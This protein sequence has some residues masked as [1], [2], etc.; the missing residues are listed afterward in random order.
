[1]NTNSSKKFVLYILKNEKNS[2]KSLKF[3]NSDTDHVVNVKSLLELPNWLKGVPTLLVTQQSKIYEGTQCLLYLQK[4]ENLLLSK[5]TEE[6]PEEKTEEKTEETP[7][8]TPKETPKE[9]PEE[10]TEEEKTEEEQTADKPEEEMIEID[11]A[12]ALV[13]AVPAN[14]L[15]ML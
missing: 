15:F 3:V 11:T 7:E 9:T 4:R 6:T 14:I 5:K 10:K 8:E 13:T 1:M 12:N 2:N